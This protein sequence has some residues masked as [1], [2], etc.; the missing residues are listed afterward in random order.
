[1][2]INGETYGQLVIKPPKMRVAFK[3][4]DICRFS[5]WSMVSS[6]DHKPL[7]R[8]SADQSMGVAAES[9]QEAIHAIGCGTCGT[10]PMDSPWVL[11]FYMGKAGNSCP[12]LIRDIANMQKD[13]R[14]YL[15]C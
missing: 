10:S 14:Q 8:E 2:L 6:G 3:T 4:G 11:E 9:I 7:Q 1:M 13:R 15:S 12:K 5:G